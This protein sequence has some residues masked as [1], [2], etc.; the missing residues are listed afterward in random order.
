MK[1]YNFKNKITLNIIKLNFKNINICI[2]SK[3]KKGRQNLRTT[4]PKAKRR[5]KKNGKG[6]SQLNIA[7][8]FKGSGPAY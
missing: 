4:D 6:C 2:L 5:G 1:I 8:I 3:G 7:L